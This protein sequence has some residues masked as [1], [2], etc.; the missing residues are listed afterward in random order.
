MRAP[1][2]TTCLQVDPPLR[3]YLAQLRRRHHVIDVP[4][5]VARAL[6]V[7]GGGGLLDGGRGLKPGA[8]GLA[9]LA[10]AG[11]DAAAA[12]LGGRDAGRLGEEVLDHW[13]GVVWVSMVGAAFGS[14]FG[15]G[16]W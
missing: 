6:L 3:E 5:H 9:L 16:A 7:A 14:R 15:K 10:D 8:V 2:K 4:R 11:H 12:D 13:W 1:L